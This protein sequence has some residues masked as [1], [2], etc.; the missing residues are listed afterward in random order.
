MTD[1]IK[2]KTVVSGGFNAG[3]TRPAGITSVCRSCGSPLLPAATTCDRCG[4]RLGL[5]ADEQAEA[6]R[7][8]LQGAIGDGFRLLELL[9][10]GGMGIVFRAREAALD[11]EVAL[12]VLTLDPVLNP[13]AFERFEREAKLA[14][15]LDHPNIVPIFAV[16]RRENIAFYTMRLVRGGSIEE[17]LQAEKALDM[18]HTLALLRDVAAALDYAHGHG[19]VHR[20]IKPGNILVGETGHAL[21]ADF[22]IA[23]AL[24]S[25]GGTVT[26]AGI[27]GSPGY[28]SPE[29][30]RGAELDGRADQY[31][32]GIVAFE[33]L[34]GRRPFETPRLQDLL[35]LHLSGEIPRPS[36][37][38]VGLSEDADAAIVRALAKDPSERFSSAAAFVDALA[39]LRSATLGTQT[40]AHQKYEQRKKLSTRSRKGA[41]LT[42]AVA[43][44]AAV[45][46]AARPEL[47]TMLRGHVDNGVTQLQN[48]LVTLANPPQVGPTV[49][50]STAIKD[51]IAQ[52]S[53]T[54]DS[55]L[56][57]ARRT[58]LPRETLR[59]SVDSGREAAGGSPAVPFRLTG[60]ASVGYV[61]VEVRGGFAPVILDGR[62]YGLSPR[63]IRVEAGTEHL[64]TVGAAD[65]FTPSQIRVTP[66]GSDTARA[67]FWTASAAAERQ[68]QLADSLKA[69]R[70]DSVRIAAARTDSLRALAK[71]DSVKAAARVDSVK[72]AVRGDSVKPKV[73]RPDS[74]KATGS[75]PPSA[76]VSTAPPPPAPS[77]AA[78]GTAPSQPPPTKTP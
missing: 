21:V 77:P 46:F 8:R 54:G 9:G 12:K 49:V 72:N 37:F 25:S 13:D 10:R 71:A 40:V 11:R 74:G 59:A 45:A 66:F 60:D 15:R 7:V 61:Y 32:L 34:T 29:Q 16:G 3:L 33:M 1:Q 17:M 68:R 69:A 4:T 43:A 26:G 39:G 20:D 19:V 70:A 24:G 5:P 52:L 48:E 35:K 53:G 78:S 22:G 44:S 36:L 50:D 14:A 47:R 31:A 30:W 55:L 6:M 18:V 41:F 62:P 63:L 58:S 38:R 57:A 76:A 51:S 73:A 75:P 65:A 23:K 64:V 56:A 67:V 28:M 42:L 2:D 27:V